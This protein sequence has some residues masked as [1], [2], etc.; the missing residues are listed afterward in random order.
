MA[1]HSSK[2]RSFRSRK[3]R[4]TLP[5]RLASRAWQTRI[6][7]PWNWAKARAGGW[8]VNRL[9][10]ERPSAP[11]R[12]VR[13]TLGTPSTCSKNRTNPSKVCSRSTERLNHQV[14][15]L[16]HD[17]M[18]EKHYTSPRAHSLVKDDTSDQSNWHSSPGAVTI[19]VD[20]AGAAVNLGPLIELRCRATLGY[21]PS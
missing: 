15:T 14:R 19:R 21:E 4:S 6:S 1:E 8:R 7:V 11:I 18:A 5:L 12:S 10:W 13:S 3:G 9:P 20:A 17:K 16:D 2:K